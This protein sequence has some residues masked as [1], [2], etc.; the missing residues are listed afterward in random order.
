MLGTRLPALQAQGNNVTNALRAQGFMGSTP[1]AQGD[2][3]QGQFVYNTPRIGGGPGTYDPNYATL[4]TQQPRN[5]QDAGNYATRSVPR[6]GGAVRPSNG[7]G[8]IPGTVGRASTTFPTLGSYSGDSFGGGLSGSYGMSPSVMG[9]FQSSITPSEIYPEWM[10]TV[11]SNTAQAQADQASNL[12]YLMK[13]FDRPGISRSD[14]H[15]AAALPFAAD[16]Q[17]Q[18]A[19]ARAQI[20]FEDAM[21]N[22]RNLFLGQVARE[23]ESLQAGNLL[24][25]LAEAQQQARLNALNRQTSLMSLVG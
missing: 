22:Q 1:Y 11:A 17:I 8:D 12:P 14:A 25:R 15:M 3:T 6:G 20:P 24:A 10:T 4:V 16:A 21:A 9:S 2:K 18:G 7:G 13:M 19:T 5:V 23:N